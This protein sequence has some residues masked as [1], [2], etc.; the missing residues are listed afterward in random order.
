MIGWLKR[1]LGVGE[2]PPSP[3]PPG[4]VRV[5]RA[6]L[7][8]AVPALHPDVELVANP[9]YGCL[10]EWKLSEEQMRRPAHSWFPEF[11]FR[12][13]R[14]RRHRVVLDDMG[15]Q[16]VELING[17]RTIAEIASSL[18]ART[19]YPDA[20]KME[21]AVLAFVTHLVRRNAASLGKTPVRK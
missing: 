21:D 1:F 7:V 6:D 5:R 11:V 19:H 8:R 2:A 14:N 20:S 10:L 4:A 17:R 15:R 13:V 3:L 9:R 16:T 18:C 12:A